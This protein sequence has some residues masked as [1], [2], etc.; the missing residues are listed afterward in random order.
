MCSL[1][2]YDKELYLNLPKVR[3][4]MNNED[5]MFLL[6][7][8]LPFQCFMRSIVAQAEFVGWH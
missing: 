1:A 6:T 4:G 2:D 3:I 7:F 8:T 5:A